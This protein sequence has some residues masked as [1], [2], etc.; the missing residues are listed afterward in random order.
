L[1]ESMPVATNKTGGWKSNSLPTNIDVI[2]DG[3]AF[4]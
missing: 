4:S 1:G 2:K 3:Y